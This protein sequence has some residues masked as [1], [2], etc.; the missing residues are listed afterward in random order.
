MVFSCIDDN[1]VVIPKFAQCP[2]CAA[3]HRVI[4]LCKSEI[5]PRKESTPALV[6]IDDIKLS[7][8]K[9]LADILLKSNADLPTW[10]QA[11]F[12]IDNQRWGDF[13]H[14]AAETVDNSKQGKVLRILGRSIF[15]VETF[16]YTTLIG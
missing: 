8:S 5:I 9:D 11:Q 15:K 10:E 4:E 7:M 3:I 1:D 2:N 14:L 12:V 13:I 16:S 6:T